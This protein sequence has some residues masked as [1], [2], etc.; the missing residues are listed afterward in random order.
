MNTQRLVKFFSVVLGLAI[1]V[2]SGCANFLKPEMGAIARP[3]ARITLPEDG[4]QDAFWQTKDVVLSYSIAT[5]DTLLNLSGE[6]VFDRSLTDSFPVIKRFTL[7][8]SFLDGEGKVI[9]TRDITPLFSSFGQAPDRQ[10]N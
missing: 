2:L 1:L 4:L 5:S 8:M 9:E 10:R 7:K 6:L 3:E